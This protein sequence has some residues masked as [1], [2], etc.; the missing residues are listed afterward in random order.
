[1]YL[2]FSFY[3]GLS[4]SSQQSNELCLL[5]ETLLRFPLAH[6]GS[7]RVHKEEDL[8]EQLELSAQPAY[9]VRLAPAIDWELG[10]FL[11]LRVSHRALQTLQFGLRQVPCLASKAHIVSPSK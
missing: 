9:G 10:R 5:P 2:I 1:M 6:I 3:S 8:W 7:R 4:L 11:H